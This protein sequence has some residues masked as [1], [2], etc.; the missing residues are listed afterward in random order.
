MTK[1]EEYT[2]AEAIKQSIE[3][4]RTITVVRERGKNQFWILENVVLVA[5][6]RDGILIKQ[7]RKDDELSEETEEG[8]GSL[9]ALG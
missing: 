4:G 3:E 5:V 2:R 9:E 7:E 8:Q 1:L 6:Y